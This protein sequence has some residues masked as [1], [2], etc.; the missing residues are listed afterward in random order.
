M[1]LINA[2]EIFYLAAFSLLVQSLGVPSHAFLQWCADI[3]LE[4]R[5]TMLLVNFSRH[6]PVLEG[7]ELKH[8][9]FI[10]E[11]TLSKR[12]L[13]SVKGETKE[14]RETV[15]E[16]AKRRETS[17]TRRMFSSR[18]ADENPRSPQRP[19]L[20]RMLSPSRA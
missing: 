17:L 11:T 16:S 8:H 20:P 13:C 9:P 10:L 18:S 4:E 15:P 5:Q 14:Q 7:S 19:S 6:I 12:Y 1:D 2:R 3:D